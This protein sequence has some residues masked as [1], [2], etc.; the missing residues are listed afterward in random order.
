MDILPIPAVSP[1]L[2]GQIVI[3]QCFAK[4]DDSDEIIPQSL[5]KY[6]G[7]LESYTISDTFF[8]FKIEGLPLAP[9]RLSTE[10]YELFAVANR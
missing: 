5:K 2:I 8:A 6:V 4:K 10:A 9:V 1:L 7:R 3:V